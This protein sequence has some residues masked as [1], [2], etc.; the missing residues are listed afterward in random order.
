MGPTDAIVLV[1]VAAALVLAARSVARRGAGG[2]SSCPDRGGCAARDGSAPCPAA[3][4]M[5][6]NVEGRLGAGA[7]D[8]AEAGGERG[9]RP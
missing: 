1:L 8:G 2:C 3:R 6:R 4:D 9:V 7:A 5:L